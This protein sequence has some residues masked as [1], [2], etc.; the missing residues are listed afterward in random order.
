M[1]K[2]RVIG[3]LIVTAQILG[4]CIAVAGPWEDGMAAYNRGD[5]LPVIRLFRPLA[6]QGNPKA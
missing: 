3:G 6:E 4:S 5:Y 1:R 2:P